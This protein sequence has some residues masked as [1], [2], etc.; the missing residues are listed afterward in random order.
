MLCELSDLIKSTDFLKSD[1]SVAYFFGK[2]SEWLKEHARKACVCE[3]V[4]GVRIPHFPQ[5]RIIIKT[6][7]QRFFE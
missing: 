3:S 6:I 4:P 7:L 5:D 1:V 2:L